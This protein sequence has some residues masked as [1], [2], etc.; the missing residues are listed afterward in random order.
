MRSLGFYLYLPKLSSIK[1]LRLLRQKVKRRSGVGK[2]PDLFLF[3]S[4]RVKS[5]FFKVAFHILLSF[6]RFN[7]QSHSGSVITIFFPL[8]V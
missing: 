6:Q 1:S 5:C 7:I 3:L 2:E 4:G 8:M